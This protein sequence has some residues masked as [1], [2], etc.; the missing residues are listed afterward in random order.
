MNGRGKPPVL[1]IKLTL[2][3]SINAQYATVDGKRV[4]TEIARKWKRH[5]EHRVELL[6]NDEILTDELKRQFS[7]SYL[8]VFMEFYFASPHRRDLD[9]GLKLALDSVCE[10]LGLNDNR[11]VEIHLVKKIDPL[12]PHLN[13]TLEAV[14]SWEFDE[15]YVLLDKDQNSAQLEE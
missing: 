4:L 5:V 14:P 15:E 13:F 11:V 3:P 2:P 12:H 10:A 8:S 7:R 1:E 6:E 9:G